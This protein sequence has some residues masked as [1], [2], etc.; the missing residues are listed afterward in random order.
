[1]DCPPQTPPSVLEF[2]LKP[3]DDDEMGDIFFF[4]L[5]RAKPHVRIKFVSTVDGLFTDK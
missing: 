4:I 5:L 1:M 2:L 3:T